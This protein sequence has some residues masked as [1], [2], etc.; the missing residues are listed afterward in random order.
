MMEDGCQTA[1]PPKPAAAYRNHD[2]CIEAQSCAKDAE[3]EC[4]SLP[5]HAIKIVLVDQDWIIKDLVCNVCQL[6]LNDQAAI[7][8]HC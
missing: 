3:G 8:V 2:T 1:P 5:A 6:I 4:P 7:C